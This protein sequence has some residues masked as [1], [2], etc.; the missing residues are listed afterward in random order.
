MD[1]KDRN[2]QGRNPWQYVEMNGVGGSNGTEE[3]TDTETGS[4]L[5][6]NNI[7]NCLST[8]YTVTTKNNVMHIIHT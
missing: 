2:K 4:L 5:S 6:V 8:A 3:D 7:E 1:R